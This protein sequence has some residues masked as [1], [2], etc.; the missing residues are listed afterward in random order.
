MHRLQPRRWRGVVRAAPRR[1]NE[2]AC[3]RTPGP[4]AR[5]RQ[6]PA[7]IPM[8]AFCHGM[9]S[10]VCRVPQS[11]A[12]LPP[13]GMG[14]RGDPASAL[15]SRHRRRSQGAQGQPR[16]QRVK[17]GQGGKGQCRCIHTVL[18]KSGILPRSLP[19]CGAHAVSSPARNFPRSAAAPSVFQPVTFRTF[20]CLSPR[21]VVAIRRRPAST[22]RASSRGGVLQ[23]SWSIHPEF[24]V[25]KLKGR[26]TSAR[27]AGVFPPG[28]AVRFRDC[29]AG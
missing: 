23:R 10:R 15:R 21:Y 12:Q 22:G 24:L 9:C 7:A 5:G 19:S 20:Q 25:R 4:A 13:A 17:Q 11:L 26:H 2:V 6:L 14:A 28:A 16:D 3:P 1:R 27:S 18:H 8:H 29:A